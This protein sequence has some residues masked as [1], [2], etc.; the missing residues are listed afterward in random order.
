MI[1]KGRYELNFDIGCNWGI[2]NGRVGLPFMV[3]W[4]IDDMGSSK[5]WQFSIDIVGF[6][7]AWEFWDWR[8]IK[9]DSDRGR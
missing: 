5:T 1:I 8:D 3:N 2:S 4:W 9:P 6:T 7:F